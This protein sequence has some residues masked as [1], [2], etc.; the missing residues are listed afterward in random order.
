LLNFSIAARRGSNVRKVL[1]VDLGRPDCAGGSQRNALE[2]TLKILT[3]ANLL[4]EQNDDGSDAALF[5]VMAVLDATTQVLVETGKAHE[6]SLL[7]ARWETL[8]A[9]IEGTSDS[10]LL[11][12]SLS[13]TTTATAA[14]SAA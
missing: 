8:R 13:V 5:L 11:E 14:A 12:P 4:V 7:R 2:Q 10:L 6:A 3:W 9:G 1:G